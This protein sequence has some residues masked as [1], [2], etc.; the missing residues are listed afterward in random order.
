MDWPDAAVV[1]GAIA[2]IAMVV[3]KAMS[4]RERKPHGAEQPPANGRIYATAVDMTE[5]R[6]RLLGLEK[7]HGELRKELREDLSNLWQAVKE[8]SCKRGFD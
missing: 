5:I 8:A 1:L 6:T 4:R 2:T 7:S 3:I